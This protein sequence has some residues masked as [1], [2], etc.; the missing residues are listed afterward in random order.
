M[1]LTIITIIATTDLRSLETSYLVIENGH[2]VKKYCTAAEETA[3][4][5]FYYD[6]METAAKETIKEAVD[7]MDFLL[8]EAYYG[9]QLRE[10][11]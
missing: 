6:F 3:L 4:P 9:S 1:E 7:I 8:I 5:K 2:T 10:L 11:P